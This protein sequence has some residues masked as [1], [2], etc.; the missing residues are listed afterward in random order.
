MCFFFTISKLFLHN[1]SPSG[2]IGLT[3]SIWPISLKEVD[4]KLE[5]MNHINIY[6][7]SEGIVK[8][9][10]RAHLEVCRAHHAGCMARQ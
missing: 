7:V 2:L 6:M 4:S 9:G 3:V 5:A 8:E 1:F 10:Y